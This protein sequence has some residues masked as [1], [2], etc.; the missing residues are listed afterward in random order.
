MC[1]NQTTPACFA[2]S[3]STCGADFH[4]NKLVAA[5]AKSRAHTV[6]PSAVQTIFKGPPIDQALLPLKCR[7]T[8]KYCVTHLNI[9]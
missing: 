2:D 6:K 3:L 4:V 1:K 9:V 7:V 5:S 8:L